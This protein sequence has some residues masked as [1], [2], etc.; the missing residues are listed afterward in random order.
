MSVHVVP[1]DAAG[2]MNGVSTGSNLIPSSHQ[3]ATWF[4]SGTTCPNAADT[5]NI[6]MLITINVTPIIPN[7]LL[8]KIHPP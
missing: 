8:R 4:S 2:T 7:L 6:N 5:P 1:P 3:K